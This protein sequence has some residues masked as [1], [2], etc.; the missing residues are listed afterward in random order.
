[1]V[2]D[3][4]SRLNNHIVIAQTLGVLKED[5]TSLWMRMIGGIRKRC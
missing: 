2:V 5:W 3:E 4:W 1:M